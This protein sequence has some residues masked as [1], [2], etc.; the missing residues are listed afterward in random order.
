[1]PSF[2]STTLESRGEQVSP[3]Q[4]FD[5][6]HSRNDGTT[7][8]NIKPSFRASETDRTKGGILTYPCQCHLVPEFFFFSVF[9]LSLF[10]F[11]PE[12]TSLA[13]FQSILKVK[14]VGEEKSYNV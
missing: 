10:H 6:H 1:M 8:D 14:N 4:V 7:D 13:L 3:G 5:R 9:F 2:Y 12:G 11:F